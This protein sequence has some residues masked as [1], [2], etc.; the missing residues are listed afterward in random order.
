MV[1]SPL[2][3]SSSLKPNLT[4]RFLY[5]MMFPVIGKEKEFGFRNIYLDSEGYPDCPECLH[6]L[7]NPL[8]TKKYSQFENRL[9][10]KE[11]F[12]GMYNIGDS[13]TMHV[14]EVPDRHLEDYHNFLIG[15]W[16]LFSPEYMKVFAKDGEIYQ[17]ITNKKPR[18]TWN[19]HLE[20]FNLNL[21]TNGKKSN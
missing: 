15:R 10:S 8:L 9:S 6:L 3:S 1:R 4:T 17:I 14:I 7:Y 20:I 13:H 16:D 12:R 21:I 5:P 19:S 18:P 11:Y 2:H